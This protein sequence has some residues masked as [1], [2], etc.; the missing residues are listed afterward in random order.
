MLSTILLQITQTGNTAQQVLTQAT[1]NQGAFSM[2]M[3]DLAVKGGWI[4]IVLAVFSI[5]AVYI[6]I[7]RFLAI[8]RSA[9]EEKNF[10]NSI[11]DFIHEGRIDSAQALCRNNNSPNC[12]DD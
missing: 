10:M 4:M 3:W 12:Q 1:G 11:R 2:S 5:I 8:N 9:K 7:D 6:F